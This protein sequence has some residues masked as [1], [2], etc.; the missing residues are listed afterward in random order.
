MADK[1]DST[2]AVVIIGVTK[3]QRKRLPTKVLGISQTNSPKTLAEWY[4][5][6]EVYVNP[7]ES[8]VNLMQNILV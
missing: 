7:Q 1:L 6:T 3:K 2:Y 4:T 5:A 8:V